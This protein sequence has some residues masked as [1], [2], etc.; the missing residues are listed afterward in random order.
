MG[1]DQVPDT[2]HVPVKAKPWYM[3]IKN[4]GMVVTFFGTIYAVEPTLFR[5]KYP[6]TVMDQAL[7][8]HERMHAWRMSEQGMVSWSWKYLMNAAFRWE[9][10]QAGYEAEFDYLRKHGTPIRDVYSL[11]SLVRVLSGPAYDNMTTEAAARI[12]AQAEFAK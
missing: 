1:I 6:R 11:E 12:W 8:R 2:F 5:L 9:E 4:A 3:K 7:L 10:E